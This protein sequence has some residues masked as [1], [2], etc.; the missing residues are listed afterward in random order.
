MFAQ[1]PLCE[2]FV[3]ISP[4]EEVKREVREIKKSFFLNNGAFPGQNSHA[5]ISLLSFFQAED[6]EDKLVYAVC[7]AMKEC[8]EFDVFLNGFGVCSS[9][10]TFYMDILD[11]QPI[12]N[13]YHRLRVKLFQQLVSLSFLRN[14]FLPHMI[15]GRT[16][17][18]TQY[19]NAVK[20]FENKL[21]TNN[22]R[23]F[24]L[25]ILKRDAPYRVWEKLIDIPLGNPVQEIW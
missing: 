22:F 4:S 13:V 20:E 5:H 9:N 17:S 7:E 24:H 6:K 12:I 19:L 23:V 11:K 14:G 2:Y 10:D 21:Y 18:S 25:T 15:I 1:S 8:R 16:V 3:L